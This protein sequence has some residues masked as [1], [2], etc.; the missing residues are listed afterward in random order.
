MGGCV[1][2]LVSFAVSGCVS[3]PSGL[4]SPAPRK[5]IEAIRDAVRTNDHTAIP[6]LL[7]LLESDDDAARVLA[8]AALQSLLADQFDEPGGPAACGYEPW[9][10]P[11]ERRGP[12]ER[13]WV[14]Y[15]ETEP[16]TIEDGTQTS[17]RV[18]IEHIEADW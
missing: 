11:I 4:D 12:V 2:G 1:L 16:S 15:A 13:L 10:G 9:M 18:R 6:G 5:R 14:W 3:A 7:A 8:Y 17:R